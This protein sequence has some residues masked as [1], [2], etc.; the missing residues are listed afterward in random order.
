MDGEWEAPLIPNPLC[1]SAP[2]CGDWQRPLIENPG[3]KGKWRPPLIDNPN[4]KGKWYPRRI[5]NPDFF[6]D[7]QPFLMAPIVNKF[8]FSFLSCGLN[9][10]MLRSGCHWFWAVDHE[11]QYSLRQRDHHRQPDRCRAIRRRLIRHQAFE[12]GQASSEYTLSHF[13]LLTAF[14][15]AGSE[16]DHYGEVFPTCIIFSQEIFRHGLI[17][18]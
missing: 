5:P 1:E 15:I 9:C 10:I 13:A 16:F 12:A 3:Y 17:I 2:G 11:W 6:E 14:E 7:L 4:Y 8:R 18:I